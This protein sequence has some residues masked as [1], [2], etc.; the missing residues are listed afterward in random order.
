VLQ[1]WAGCNEVDDCITYRQCKAWYW[2][3]CDDGRFANYLLVVELS[4]V[5]RS[6]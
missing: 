4:S 3:G 1:Y 6:F 5:I 2:P